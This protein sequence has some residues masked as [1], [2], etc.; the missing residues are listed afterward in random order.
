VKIENKKNYKKISKEEII[1]S[2]DSLS[3]FEIG[4]ILGISEG[5]TKRIYN[6]AISRLRAPGFARLLWEYN[7][8]GNVA[9]HSEGYAES[10]H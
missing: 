8:I 4:E 7:N 1:S 5:E 2:G 3:F 9:D 10:S 6:R